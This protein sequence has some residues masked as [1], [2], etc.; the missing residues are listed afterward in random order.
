MVVEKE[1]QS[2][3]NEQQYHFLQTLLDTIPS[4]IFYKDKAGQYLGCNKAFEEFTGIT[5]GE[6]IGKT[7]DDMVLLGI[8]DEYEKKDRDPCNQP[9][10]QRYEWKIKAK[11]G[12]HRSVIFDKA[13]FNDSERNPVG[14][15]GIISDIT[16]RSR[17]ENEIKESE[18]RLQLILDTIHTGIMIID[19]LEHKI[20]DI[21]PAALKM[22]GAQKEE[23]VG[24]ACHQFICP[25]E[26]GKCPITDLKQDIDNTE[27]KIITRDGMKLSVLKRVNPIRIK[28]KE[29]LLESFIDITDL[30]EAQNTV[31]QENA[32]F[33]AMISGMEEGVVL[34]D[35]NNIIVEVNQYFCNLFDRQKQEILGRRIEDFHQAET[36]QKVNRYIYSF[37]SGIQ[38]KP[39][40]IVQRSLGNEEIILRIQPIYRNGEYDGVLFNVL[41]VTDLVEA[42]QKA[43]EA[44]RAKSEFLANMSHEIRTPMNAIMGFTEILDKYITDNQQRH[45]LKAIQA[46]GKSLLNLINDILDLSKVEVGKLELDY[47]P[48]NPYALFEEIEQIFAHRIVEKGLE[49]AVDVDQELPEGLILDEV[50][51]RQILVN[52]VGNA[53]KFTEKGYIKLSVMKCYTD[54]NQNSLDLFFSVADSGIGIPQDQLESIFEAFTQQKGQSQVKYGGTGLGLA[55]TKRLVNM[56][57]GQIHVASKPGQGSS[58]SVVL[59]DV[60]TSRVNSSIRDEGNGFLDVKFEKATILVIDDI[61][62]NR[63]LLRGMLAEYDFQILMAENGKEGIKL[64]QRHRPALILMDLKMPVMDGY[65]A[66]KRLKEDEKTKHIP[67]IIVT[68]SAMKRD[69]GKIKFIADDYILKPIDPYNFIETLMKFLPC[70]LMNKERGIVPLNKTE[71]EKDGTLGFDRGTLKKLPHLLMIMEGELSGL[72]EEISDTLTINDIEDFSKKIKKL[73]LDYH[74]PPLYQWAEELYSQAMIFDVEALPHTLKRID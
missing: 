10:K 36:L 31:Q 24:H 63:D 53:V 67:V 18:T 39:P 49:F 6:I 66:T 13:T 7:V 47:S 58:F 17:M 29:Y 72:W 5:E 68:A 34:A 52:L 45:Y 64:A 70:T 27:R 11:D 22:I 35:R 54:E 73:G 44:N 3:E 61:D 56:M 15:V 8:V 43:E 38:E 40:V 46:S 2:K 19:P 55:I 71:T 59:N 14:M 25:T 57:G 4:P 26:I 48:V 65:E 33:S 20:I 32:K 41:N 74:Y 9:G 37:K 21:N 23:V 16:E 12:Q 62:S 42:R 69:E 51:L 30:K 50:R 60:K 1:S 28:G